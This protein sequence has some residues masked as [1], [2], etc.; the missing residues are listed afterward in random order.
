[1]V[2]GSAFGI[3]SLVYCVLMIIV[4]LYKRKAN[5]TG[6]LTNLF[7]GLLLIWTIIVGIIEIICIWAIDSL[8][9]QLL[10]E[11]LCRIHILVDI[12]IF[13]LAIVYC[14]V[15]TV[16][17][18]NL[19]R[20]TK[21]RRLLGIFVIT[22]DS[23]IY[24]ITLFLPIEYNAIIIPHWVLFRGPALYPVYVL[25][26]IVCIFSSYLIWRYRKTNPKELTIPAAYFGVTFI[27][28]ALIEVVYFDNGINYIYTLIAY[29]MIG[30]F[31]TTESQDTKL[32][33]DAEESR[34]SAEA[35]NKAKSNFLASI[36]HAIRTPM[37]TVLGFSQS[38]LE[39]RELTEE[40]VKKDAQDIKEASTNLL[41]LINNI[42]DISRIESGKEE[43]EAKEYKVE[44]LLREI[45][46]LIISKI[47]RD[48]LDFKI[49][50]DSNIPVSYKGDSDKI[51]KIIVN[52]LLNAIQNT[53]YGS[54]S[55]DVGGAYVGSLFKLSLIVS[56]SGHLMTEEE[57][58]KDFD[59][60]SEDNNSQGTNKEKLGLIVAK[61]LIDLMGGTIDFKNETGK[62]TRYIISLDQEVVDDMKIGTV[63]IE[64]VGNVEDTPLDL[65]GLKALLVDDNN[66]NIK[67]AAR[68]LKQFKLDVTTASNGQECIDLV[69]NG[70]FD[71]VFLDHLMP[72]M[73]GVEAVHVLRENGN[74]MP[75]IALTANS[76]SGSREKYIEEGFTDYLPKPFQ[77][78]DL[79]K[80]LRKYMGQ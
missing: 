34:E 38:L 80:V 18:S 67:I 14:Y 4:Y 13:T 24:L 1:M 35:A 27:L 10:I 12:E 76:Y 37:N 71:I 17:D 51:Y 59:E 75:I 66:V 74:E 7:Y 60:F 3:V 49:N 33:K 69:K 22:F 56:N 36:S 26:I 68:L 19:T 44:E 42:L 46:S 9:N 23:I 6:G 61:R 79:N 11:I 50:V 2:I 58:N 45:N 62:G 25:G 20:Y 41:E 73:D 30:T 29:F 72:G 52:V 8:S 78:K 57:F 5:K 55:L 43:V 64:S 65:T 63:F 39:E 21:I 15:A 47:S 32:L 77:Y 53:N 70:A 54:V 31:F 28:F 48:Q 40:K 16:D